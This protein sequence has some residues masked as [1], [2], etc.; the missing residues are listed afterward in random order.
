MVGCW[1][2]SLL[3]PNLNRL[4]RFY[5]LIAPSLVVLLLLLAV[6]PL[7]AQDVVTA[8]QV[9]QIAKGMYCPVCE[10]E[11]LDTCATQACADWRAEIRAQLEAGRTEQQIY[12]D[13]VARYGERV[14]AQPSSSGLNLILWLG[15]PLGLIA[16]GYLFYAYLRRIR[17][18][19]ASIDAA[20]SAPKPAE[21][22]E[23]VYMR[24]VEAE[25]SE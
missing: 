12:A 24:R 5:T 23:D 15:I 22:S 10:S 7:Y 2:M 4:V 8:D 16:G 1:L 6:A 11:P 13:F 3:M 14:L 19:A 17:Q 25:L 21:L 18:P 20:Q 9:N